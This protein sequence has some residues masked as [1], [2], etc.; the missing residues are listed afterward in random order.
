MQSMSFIIT[1]LPLYLHKWTVPRQERTV[2]NTG[3][4]LITLE[5]HISRL[6]GLISKCYPVVVVVNILQYYCKIP[7]LS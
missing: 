5:Y 2:L 4:K 6:Q 1:S 3:L 7:V